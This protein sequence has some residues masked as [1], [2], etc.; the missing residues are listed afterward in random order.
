MAGAPDADLTA[1]A[2][3]SALASDATVS[4]S[5]DVVG[6]PTEAA[7]VVLAEKIGVS[8]AETRLAY[9]RVATVPF[10]SAY[11]FMATFHRLPY[12]GAEPAGRAGQGRA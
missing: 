5:G 10:D 2:Y 1:L 8:V 12:Q 7:V 9:P 11:K 3:V 6:D 4:R